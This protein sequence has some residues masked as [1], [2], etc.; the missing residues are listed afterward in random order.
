MHESLWSFL[1]EIYFHFSFFWP[2]HLRGVDVPLPKW[3]FEGVV[4]VVIADFPAFLH[5][6]ILGQ[7]L[8]EFFLI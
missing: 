7:F 6:E 2:V 1:D 3:L 5:V 8:I 4:V